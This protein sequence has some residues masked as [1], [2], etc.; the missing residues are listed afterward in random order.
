MKHNCWHLREKKEKKTDNSIFIT[1]ECKKCHKIM[2]TKELPHPKQ[3]RTYVKG[4]VVKEAFAHEWATGKL[5]Q[6]PQNATHAYLALKPNVKVTTAQTLGSQLLKDPLVQQRIAKIYKDIGF[7]KEDRALLLKRNAKQYT[8]YSA[9]NQAIEIAEK[10]EAGFYDKEAGG[11]T[12][13][14]AILLDM[15]PEYEKKLREQK[16]EE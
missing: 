7:T 2:Q 15:I 9:S 12:T 14:I 3:K 6:K 4:K 10:M 11:N 1:M 16:N 5:S 8:S 13:N